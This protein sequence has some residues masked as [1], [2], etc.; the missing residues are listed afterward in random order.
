MSAIQKM[1]RQSKRYLDNGTKLLSQGRSEKASE[2]LWGAV[3]LALKAVAEK[4]GWKHHSHALLEDV[5]SRLARKTGDDSLYRDFLAAE[6]LHRNFYNIQYSPRQVRRRARIVRGLVA[7][8]RKL[9]NSP[10]KRRPR[11]AARKP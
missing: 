5:A 3:A 2:L 6:S 9:S 11:K 7:E 8:L 4:N 10:P 1:R